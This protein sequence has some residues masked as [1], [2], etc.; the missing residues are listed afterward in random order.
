MVEQ[1]I[2]GR[3][4]GPGINH[5]CIWAGGMGPMDGGFFTSI[6]YSQTAHFGIYEFQY[7]GISA[8]MIYLCYENHIGN[9]FP[10]GNYIAG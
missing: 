7:C 9:Q 2:T 8:C 6:P 1:H 3:M 4:T 5:G 10:R